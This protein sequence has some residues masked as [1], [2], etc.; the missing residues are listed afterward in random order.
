MSKYNFLV[1]YSS[2]NQSDRINLRATSCSL[3]QYLARYWLS[4]HCLPVE[5]GRWDNIPRSE[6]TC[7]HCWQTRRIRMVGTEMHYAGFCIN[8]AEQRS[9]FIRQRDVLLEELRRKSDEQD[10]RTLPR[11]AYN[12]LEA[13]NPELSNIDLRRLMNKIAYF[14]KH[15]ILHMRTQWLSTATESTEIGFRM[16]HG[17]DIYQ[18]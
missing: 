12:T 16:Y 17:F 8:F 15:I 1:T 10:I 7:P 11:H 3:A 2:L 18:D 4:Q 6:R 13:S 14:T 5:T 9:A